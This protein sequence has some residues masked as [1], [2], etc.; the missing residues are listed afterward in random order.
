MAKQLNRDLP[1]QMDWIPERQRKYFPYTAHTLWPG[2]EPERLDILQQPIPYMGVQIDWVEAVQTMENWLEQ[3]VGVRYSS[4][5]WAEHLAIS[6][7]HCGV[8]FHRDRDRTLFLLRWDN[9]R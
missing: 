5:V 2:I 4:W 9:S 3:S 1:P 7:W 8:A 6:S